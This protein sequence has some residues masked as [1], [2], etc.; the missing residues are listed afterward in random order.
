MQ[1]SSKVTNYYV[2]APVLAHMA[3]LSFAQCHFPTA[4]KTAQVLPLLKKPG[5]DRSSM[6]NFRPISNLS[7]VSKVIGSR[8][9]VSDSWAFL[10]MSLVPDDTNSLIE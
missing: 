10:L 9:F 2:I 4:F 6:S 3:N 7:T 1:A 8:G 5:L